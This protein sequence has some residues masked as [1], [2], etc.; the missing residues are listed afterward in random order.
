MSRKKA[1]GITRNEILDAAWEMIAAQGAEVSM[2]DI[3]IATGV[4]RQSVYLHFKSRGG[5]LI[6]LVKRADER[7]GIEESF[8][9]AMSYPSAADRLDMCLQKWFEF[10]V[11]IKPVATD[12]IRLRK[13]DEDAAAAWEGRMA[14]LWDWERQL[15]ET[16]A[17]DGKL[18]PEWNVEDA[19]DY[20]WSSSSMQMWD[21]LTTEKGWSIEK[22]SDKLRK[23]ISRSILK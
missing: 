18:S 13:T 2:K 16:I 10:V 14:V 9:S 1:A 17:S 6:E 20:L 15:V 22:A 4:S 5:L 11:K 8:F 23:T 3:A 7:F 12:L 19:T 21:L